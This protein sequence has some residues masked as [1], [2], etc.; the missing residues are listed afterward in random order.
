METLYQSGA[1]LLH[2]L[3][4]GAKVVGL[5]LLFV[6]SLLF[7]HPA[8]QGLLFLGV[9][10]LVWAGRVGRTVVRLAP[11]WITLFAISTVLWTFM[12]PGGDGT[13]LF[14]VWKFAV[15]DRAL[16]FGL[17]M[18]TRLAGLLI[19]GLCFI[20]TTEVE[21]FTDGLHRLGLPY[22]VS[23]TLSL[24]FRLVPLLA[25]T[26]SV[27]LEAQRCRGVDPEAGG[28]LRRVRGLVPLMV[29]IFLEVLRKADLMAVALESKGFGRAGKRSWAAAPRMRG[30]DWAVVLG[31]LALVTASWLLRRAGVG[32]L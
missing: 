29:P 13:V 5:V 22:P 8:A 20:V 9:L 10:G 31:L 23:F 2:R 16:W 6:E 21:A 28:L 12:Y 14:L 17:A 26:G 30:E 4:P 24:S 1:T 11:L 7:T 19:L 32:Q 25:E 3:H 18:G 15:T 27:I